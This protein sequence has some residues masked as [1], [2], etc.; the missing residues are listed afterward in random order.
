MDLHQAMVTLVVALQHLAPTQVE[1][2]LQYL[3]SDPSQ[4]NL[5]QVSQLVQQVS[6]TQFRYLVTASVPAAT[7]Q[8][9]ID[10]QAQQLE[11][12]GQLSP[13]QF[14]SFG[15]VYQLC[16]LRE[17][18]HERFGAAYDLLFKVLEVVPPVAPEQQLHVLNL[19]QL[20]L[21]DV[22]PSHLLEL[23][24]EVHSNGSSIAQMLDLKHDDPNIMVCEPLRG[25]LMAPREDLLA[26]QR[27]VTALDA[28]QLSQLVQLTQ[29][30]PFELMELGHLI[31]PTQ[32]EGVLGVQLPADAM[33]EEDQVYVY[34]HSIHL[35]R[36][37]SHHR[38]RTGYR[39]LSLRIVDQPPEKSVYK[40]NLKPNPTVHVVGRPTT[41]APEDEL[42]LMP[43][44]IRCDT[45]QE[46]P[47]KLSGHAPIK[48]SAGSITAFRRIKVL[49]TSHQLD[50]TLFALRFE[51][52]RMRHGQL[53]EV[54]CFVQSTPMAIVSHS[55]LMK[56]R[57]SACSPPDISPSPPSPP[58]SHAR[59]SV[60][61]TAAI[62]PPVILEICPSYGSTAGGTKVAIIGQNFVEGPTARVKVAESYIVEPRFHDTGTL[63]C[64]IPKH[65]CTGEV[66]IRV[67][68]D[69]TRWS[70]TSMKFVYIDP[71]Q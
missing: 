38:C 44:L 18:I 62:A 69:S 28:Y 30:D 39:T 51:L 40:R 34:C 37:I 23:Q 66:E 61:T 67:S 68:N 59:S 57:T 21:I 35:F 16:R 3:L 7:L 10:E 12:L 58:R 50:E 15:I 13:V 11:F 43:K 9:N 17:M 70:E 20:L 26:I 64:T 46:V 41:L 24:D 33:V 53:Q 45:Q 1:R 2:I 32:R 25:L 14:H 54:V 71:L 52:L 29:I 36:S 49:I 5:S 8:L 56:T 60:A 63:I 22:M 4:F 65:I 42:Y 31:L 27:A 6:E 48:V 47:D 19:L 55:T